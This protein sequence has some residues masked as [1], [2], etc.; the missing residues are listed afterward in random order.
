MIQ[1]LTVAMIFCMK[2]HGLGQHVREDF[3]LKRRQNNNKDEHKRKHRLT[4]KWGH[5][6]LNKG[7]FV[8]IENIPSSKNIL[9]LIESTKERQ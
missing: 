7:T 3:S 8:N 6:L 2:L 4:V 1:Y 9:T 5:K